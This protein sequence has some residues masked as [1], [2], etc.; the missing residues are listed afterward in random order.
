MEP[1]PQ[2]D[3]HDPLP[4]DLAEVREQIKYWMSRQNEGEAGSNWEHTV[5]NKIDQLRWQEQR[6]GSFTERPSAEMSA[7]EVPVIFL[8]CGQYRE[9]EKALG[10]RVKELL[11]GDGCVEVY[12]A[13]YQSTFEAFTKNILGALNRCIGFIGIMHHRGEVHTPKG[14]TTRAS[15]WIEQEIAIAA[16]IE[17]ILNRKIEVQ[18]YIQEGIAR[19]GMRDQL[20]I[21][22]QNFRE[23][24]EILDHLAR[25][26]ERW[27][28][29]GTRITVPDP[30]R[31]ANYKRRFD[32]TKSSF[33]VRL[34]RPED[35]Q[36][37]RSGTYFLVSL[38]PASFP[39]FDIDLTVRNAFTEDI[40][41]TFSR[42][43]SLDREQGPDI[44]TEVTY[45]GAREFI[46]RVTSQNQE[47]RWG[48]MQDGTVRFIAQSVWAVAGAQN[49]AWSAYD[50]ATDVLSFLMLAGRFWKKRNYRGDARLYA[51]L[52]TE[53]AEL[54][55]DRTGYPT[56]F[57][58]LTTA[59]PE[60]LTLDRDAI[61]HTHAARGYSS[62]FEDI[63]GNALNAG[64]IQVAGKVAGEI[65]NGLGYEVDLQKLR[66]FMKR[67]MAP[68]A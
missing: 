57:H 19:E 35:G 15:V 67:T 56:L 34:R 29:I 55:S 49:P 62:V 68:H 54:H 11:E 48:F 47:R 17:Q 30:I 28:G 8:S 3:L 38:I 27:R 21:N 20:L 60:T 61:I 23:N 65:F 6:L 32:Q 46:L 2:Y 53:K 37:T 13:E 41:E 7:R 43:K 64:I 58:Q 42:H 12:F 31:E 26:V 24:S 14:P 5:R 25:N 44:A 33:Y 52:K 51:E 45:D 18:L 36:D 9:E 59:L 66:E 10:K 39:P 1:T 50:V 4:E 16:F 40:Y 22:A 63:T